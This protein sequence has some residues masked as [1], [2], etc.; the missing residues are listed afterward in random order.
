MNVKDENNAKVYNINKNY[1]VV[2]IKGNK[3]SLFFKNSQNKLLASLEG[4]NDDFASI[5]ISNDGEL[6]SLEKKYLFSFIKSQNFRISKDIAAVLNISIIKHLDGREEYLT[7]NQIK[8]R[9]EKGLDFAKVYVGKLNAYTL[10]IPSDSKDTHYD[11]TNAAISRLSVTENNNIT[12]DLR[13][14][15][16]IETISIDD[17][18]FGTVNMSR[19]NVESVF[20]G[21]KCRCNLNLSDSKKCLNIQIGDIYSGNLNINNSCLYSFNVGYYSYA[22]IHLSNN[23]I[24]KSIEIGDSFRGSIYAD[25]QSCETLKIG[26]DCKGEIIVGCQIPSS[27]I[28][29]IIISHDFSG[30]LNLS[31]D[32]SVAEIEIGDKSSAQLK[33]SFSKAL[34]KLK[35]GKYHN[36]NIELNNSSI[37]EI[38]IDK[39]AT[40]TIEIND[41]HQLKTV[42]VPADNKLQING[43][44]PN[45]NIK[46]YP[47]EHSHAFLFE[48]PQNKTSPFY[49]KIYKEIQNLFP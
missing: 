1:R 41:C 9:I 14:N 48:T 22:D 28:K 34:N 38:F 29:K 12:I 49:K 24:K 44:I 8:K 37:K 26:D 11:L 19:S 3:C 45:R 10:K 13:D 46:K 39:Y 17:N 30:T 42:H 6:S 16:Y 47:L 2:R 15:K 35:I 36:G 23:I 40:G 32:E 25:N 5:L 21:N 20:L 7:E 33:A 4:C 43:D 27:G 31:G 18:F